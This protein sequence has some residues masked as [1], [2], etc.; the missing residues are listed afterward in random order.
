[1]THKSSNGLA[2]CFSPLEMIKKK[3]YTDSL[4]RASRA[5]CKDVVDVVMNGGISMAD[6][7][8]SDNNR[9]YNSPSHLS[10]ILPVFGGS[11]AATTDT[12][13]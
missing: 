7:L 11:S 4:H 6:P 3:H 10:V 9:S 8:Q 1:M 2:V 13:I 5:D 12:L